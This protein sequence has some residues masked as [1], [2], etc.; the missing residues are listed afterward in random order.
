MKTIDI[1]DENN[2]LTGEEAEFKEA[3]ANNMWHR[4][5]AIILMNNQERIMMMKNDSDLWTTPTGVVESGEGPI[6]TAVRVANK[7]FE[8]KVENSDLKLLIVTKSKEESDHSFKYYYLLKGD[9]KLGEME[10]LIKDTK[11]RFMSF[12]DIM[13]KFASDDEVFESFLNND[14]VEIINAYKKR[15]IEKYD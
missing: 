13:E 14:F 5:V 12:D 7:K 10:E 8:L 4:D 2:V 6:F 15:I 3:L 1:V 9:Y 11:I